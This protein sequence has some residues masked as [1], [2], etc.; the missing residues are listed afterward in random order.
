MKVLIDSPYS[1][2]TIATGQARIFGLGN[3]RSN[4]SVEELIKAMRLGGGET[5]GGRSPTRERFMVD[6][7][8]ALYVLTGV[9]HGEDKALWQEWWRKNK[10][11]FRIEPE[12]PQVP[13]DVKSTWE[14][15][16][17]QPY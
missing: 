5:R 6:A 4:D 11:T 8:I 15:Y 16:W 13:A 12:R 10:K 9:D 7:R 2:L 14:L 3:I 1:G 17:N